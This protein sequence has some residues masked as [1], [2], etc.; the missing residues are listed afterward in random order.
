MH[1]GMH[2]IGWGLPR[3][4]IAVGLTVSVILLVY[5][6]IVFVVVAGQAVTALF[7]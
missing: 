2:A 1:T 6:T 4:A 5:S 7:P 3:L